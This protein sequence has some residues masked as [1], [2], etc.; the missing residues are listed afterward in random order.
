MYILVFY[1]Y[2]FIKKLFILHVTSGLLKE[3]TFHSNLTL[4]QKVFSIF[5]TCMGALTDLQQKR[6]FR[7]TCVW[8]M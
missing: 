6:L 8:H 2:L 7:H 5:D 4:R 3:Q 1:M